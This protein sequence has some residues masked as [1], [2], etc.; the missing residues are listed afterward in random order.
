[1]LLIIEVADTAAAFDLQR[2]AVR[3]AKAGV[4]EY[5]LLALGRRRLAVHRQSDTVT[6][7][8]R[9]EKIQVAELFPGTV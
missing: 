5:W 2:K 6:P 4:P 1:L 8:G 9:T 7:E 3:D